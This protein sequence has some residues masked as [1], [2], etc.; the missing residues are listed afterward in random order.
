MAH[1]HYDDSQGASIYES[2]ADPVFTLT[3]GLTGQAEPQPP[4]VAGKARR[5]IDWRDY[6]ERR[7]AAYTRSERLAIIHYL[8]YYGC[9]G[10]YYEGCIRYGETGP[11]VIEAA[12][13]SYWRPSLKAVS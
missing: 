2:N 1:L 3:H 4:E 11:G 8:E 5:V 6:A 10:A 12:L 9:D 7:F 13:E